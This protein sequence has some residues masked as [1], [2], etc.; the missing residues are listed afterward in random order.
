MGFCYLKR[1]IK[2]L[3]FVKRSLGNEKLVEEIRVRMPM[4]ELGFESADREF[5][6]LSL[7]KAKTNLVVLLIDRLL[8]YS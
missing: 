4:M 2:G 8:N 6:S 1:K 3:S 7:S 5:V